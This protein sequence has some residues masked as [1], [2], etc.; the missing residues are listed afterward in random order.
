LRACCAPRAAAIGASMSDRMAA[1]ES[2]L[3]EG[4]R[5]GGRGARERG[6]AAARYGPADALRPRPFRRACWQS[7]L[8]SARA[9]AP[10][11]AGAPG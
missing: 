3:G 4:K 2:R 10:P 1:P 11:V 5:A 7:R 6:A 9:K 8:S